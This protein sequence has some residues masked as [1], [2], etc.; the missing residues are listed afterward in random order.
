MSERIKCPSCGAGLI[1]SEAAGEWRATCPRCLAEID[2]PEATPAPDAVQA[3]SPE[4]REQQF[5]GR[6]RGYHSRFDV[7]VR[8]DRTRTNPLVIIL[9]VIGG[10]GVGFLGLTALSLMADGQY[11]ALLSLAAPLLLLAGISTLIV[12]VR[13]RGN[14]GAGGFRRVAVG[15]LA[16]AGVATLMILLLIMAFIVFLFIVCSQHHGSSL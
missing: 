12:M 11:S 4:R 8:R 13:S 1:L 3:E 15:T 6:E 7:D 9:A 5:R 14:P 10:L 2:V 16:L